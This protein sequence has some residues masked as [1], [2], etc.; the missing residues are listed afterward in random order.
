M[1]FAPMLEADVASWSGDTDV[2]IVG[3]GGAGACAAIAAADSGACGI[4][5]LSGDTTRPSMP[6]RELAAEGRTQRYATLNPMP[7]PT[8][9]KQTPR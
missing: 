2:I 8:K 1:S 5:G 4:G 9:T 6:M 7:H 3:F